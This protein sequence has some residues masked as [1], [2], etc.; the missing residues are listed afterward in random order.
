[1]AKGENPVCGRLTPVEGFGTKD[2]TRMI[3]IRGSRII[4]VPD[5]VNQKGDKSV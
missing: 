3:Q 5:D 1:M 4:L 2:V